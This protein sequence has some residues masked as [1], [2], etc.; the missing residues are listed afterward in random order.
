MCVRVRSAS[1]FMCMRVLSAIVIMCVR[2]RYAIVIVPEKFSPGCS[3]GSPL[4]LLEITHMF[5]KI[6]A[7]LFH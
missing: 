2:V 6:F 7:P 1:V 5:A 4:A 3:I